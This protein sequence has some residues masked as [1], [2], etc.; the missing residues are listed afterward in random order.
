MSA[1]I[2]APFCSPPDFLLLLRP[3]SSPF[4]RSACSTHQAEAQRTG[5]RRR[6]DQFDGHWIAEAI[7]S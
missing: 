2:S 3:V 5:D 6:L 4:A 1:A 7:G